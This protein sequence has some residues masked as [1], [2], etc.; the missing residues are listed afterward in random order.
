MEQNKD[1]I[2][3]KV[4]DNRKTLSGGCVTVMTSDR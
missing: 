1:Q 4:F 3:Y 2:V